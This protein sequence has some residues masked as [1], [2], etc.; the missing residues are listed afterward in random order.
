MSSVKGVAIMTSAEALAY[1]RELEENQ[2]K[3]ET[4][5]KSL[6]NWRKDIRMYKYR[7]IIE[8]L[9]EEDIIRNAEY[10]ACDKRLKP[11]T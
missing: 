5:T 6:V 10:I 8:P 9:A 7:I 3:D 1:E 4:S 2:K 11:V